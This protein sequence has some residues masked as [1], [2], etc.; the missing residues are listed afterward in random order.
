[1]PRS[2]RCRCCRFRGLRSSSIPSK[3]LSG[4]S[5]GGGRGGERGG[6]PVS[7]NRNTVTLTLAS[8]VPYGDTVTVSY[9]PGT[10]P[11][12]D[13]NDNPATEL[14]DYPVSNTSPVPFSLLSATV[15]GTAL[16]ITYGTA[17]DGASVPNASAFTV[18]DN[19]SPAAVSSVDITGSTTVLTLDD[20]IPSGDSGVTVS[21]VVPVSNPIK[22]SQDTNMASSFSDQP[23]TDDAPPS[24][25]SASVIDT[26]LTLEYDEPLDTG[27]VPT[28]K[29]Y[30]V[31]DS[32]SAV[33]PVSVSVDGSEIVITLDYPTAYGDTVT[34]D[35][36]PGS[37]PLLSLM[38]DSAA[39]SGI[40]FRS[41]RCQ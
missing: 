6:G 4:S 21:Y 12:K 32:R 13:M 10:N 20:P 38:G 34:V 40:A 16:T 3:G 2:I 30:A 17:L 27:S 37:N 19:G 41:I 26:T 11:I 36:A 23:V 8:P 22:N 25:V 18:D 5:V 15:N 14:D 24:L 28:T 33:D 31:N 39:V 1:M 35:Y 7:I 9:I 29:D